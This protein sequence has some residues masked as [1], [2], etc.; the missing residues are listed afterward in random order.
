MIAFKILWIS[1]LE[2]QTG[3]SYPYSTLGLWFYPSFTYKAYLLYSFNAF[4]GSCYFY[5][6]CICFLLIDFLSFCYQAIAFNFFACIELFTGCQRMKFF[7]L[8]L[9]K[10]IIIPLNT[11]NLFQQAVKLLGNRWITLELQGIAKMVTSTLRT[12]LTQS[13]CQ[14]DAFLHILSNNLCRLKPLNSS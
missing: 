3:S 7:A 11:T 14:A 4:V 10:K 13:N 1:C 5:C 12:R 8:L 6:V 9:F 2:F